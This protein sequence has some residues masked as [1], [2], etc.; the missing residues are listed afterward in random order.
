MKPSVPALRTGLATDAQTVFVCNYDGSCADD[1]PDCMDHVEVLREK[2]GR[3][4][5]EI[6][7]IQELNKQYRL[8]ESNGPG[9]QIFHIA[10][11]CLQKPSANA[12]DR[13]VSMEISHIAD[14]SA[15]RM[16]VETPV[17]SEYCAARQNLPTISVSVRWHIVSRRI[18]SSAQTAKV[19]MSGLF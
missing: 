15:S 16:I 9:A 19:A 14:K 5:V 12:L 4:R 11:A 13:D 8:G 7:Q 10:N 1:Y 6:A 3:L 18:P 17:D 2:I